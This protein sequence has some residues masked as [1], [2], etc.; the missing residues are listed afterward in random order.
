MMLSTYCATSFN[1]ELKTRLANACR[2]LAAAV[3]PT[4]KTEARAMEIDR[5]AADLRTELDHAHQEFTQAHDDLVAA[6]KA[7][8]IELEA[9]R[10][11]MAAQRDRAEEVA[12]RSSAAFDALRAELAGTKVAAE[13]AARKAAIDADAVRMDLATIRARADAALEVMHELR[14]RSAAEAGRLT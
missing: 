4:D 9:L 14:D 11:D 13:E 2:D 6:R 10:A 12:A 1:Q 5:R 3:A 8:G 7:H